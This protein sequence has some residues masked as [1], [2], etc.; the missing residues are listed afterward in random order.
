LF[1]LFFL[2]FHLAAA[3]SFTFA[4]NNHSQ[5]GC[6]I[7]F[8]Y[9]KYLI[10]CLGNIGSEYAHTR[11]NAGFAAAEAIVPPNTLFQ[12]EHLG[13]AAHF[14]CRGRQIVVLKPS[15]YMNGSGR[16]VNY[17]LQRERIPLEHLLVAVDDIAIPFGGIRMRGGGSDGGHNGL[18]DIIAMLHTEQFARLR[19][20]IGSNYERGRQ[21]D[22]VLGQWTEQERLALPAILNAAA[23]AALDFVMEGLQ[24]AMN[25][26]NRATAQ[27]VQ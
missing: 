15:T 8:T 23:A 27:R 22:Y 1:L 14:R 16:A 9:M 10:A 13:A 5:H 4:P 7:A 19:I 3:N 25:K 2:T 18:K 11:H 20:G 6:A 26:H 21:I 12:S 24:S 17:W